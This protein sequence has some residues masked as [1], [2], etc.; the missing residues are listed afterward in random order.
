M[1][2]NI[3]GNKNT[4]PQKRRQK[5]IQPPLRRPSLQRTP[6]TGPGRLTNI[7]KRFGFGA[8]SK[9]LKTPTVTFSLSKQ[10]FSRKQFKTWK[11]KRS[12][13]P[14]N[15]MPWGEV[16]RLNASSLLSRTERN[17]IE[18]QKKKEKRRKRKY[19]TCD[20]NAFRPIRKTK[21]GSG[22]TP[23]K[24]CLVRVPRGAAADALFSQHWINE[25][26][27]S[28]YVRSPGMPFAE[29]P[30]T[31]FLTVSPFVRLFP[32]LPPSFS[33]SSSSSLSSLSHANH[34]ASELL[35]V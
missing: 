18:R 29:R 19:S 28:N 27:R 10:Q 24:P 9:I 21:V 12:R 3:V 26:K 17:L 32:F 16:A 8:I 6:F 7:P 31:V 13:S 25:W 5:Q 4:P 14:M 23:S 35:F 15:R 2:G 30:T 33:S 11:K 34:L 1:Y 22:A 20:T